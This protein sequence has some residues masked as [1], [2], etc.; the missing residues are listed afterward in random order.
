MPSGVHDAQRAI[1]HY[2]GEGVIRDCEVTIAHE[3]ESSGA[4][5]NFA[6]G[7][8]SGVTESLVE[9]CPISLLE[10]A[11]AF[12]SGTSGSVTLRAVDIVVEGWDIGPS[13]ASV[14]GGR[15]PSLEG[16]T[17]NGSS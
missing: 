9:N 17:L 4:A 14:M 15:T 3:S 1:W 12:Y 16:V 6:I 5:G 11:D 10:P 8:R 13:M 7:A 2:A